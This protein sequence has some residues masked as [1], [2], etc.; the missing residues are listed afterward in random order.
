MPC[1]TTVHVQLI[2]QVPRLTTSYINIFAAELLRDGFGEEKYYRC[3]VVEQGAEEEQVTKDLVA[4]SPPQKQERDLIGYAC[5]FY[6]YSTWEGRTLFIDDIF[7]RDEFRSMKRCP[8]SA[9]LYHNKPLET[10]KGGQGVC[11]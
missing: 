10:N 5:Y 7:V 9:E 2:S 4:L 3:L 8:C 11:C 1:C 6:T